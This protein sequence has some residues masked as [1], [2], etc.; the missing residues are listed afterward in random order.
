MS[1]I[2]WS[3]P[4]EMFGLLIEYVRDEA[5]TEE[6][7]AERVEFLREL[8]R[9][10]HKLGSEELD[11][12]NQLADAMRELRDAQPREF[13]ND[14]VIAHLDECIAEL[15]RIALGTQAT[16]ATSGQRRA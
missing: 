7:D 4:E 12:A 9:G 3:D 10:L 5:L 11:R 16:D 13:V 6:G 15:Q 14:P 1:L 2:D 8:S